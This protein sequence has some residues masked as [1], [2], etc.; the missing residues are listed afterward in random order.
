MTTAFHDT[1]LA[2]VESIRRQGIRPSRGGANF[3]DPR[4]QVYGHLRPEGPGT[5][6]PGRARIEYRVPNE[7]IIGHGTGGSTGISSRGEVP[8]EDVLHGYGPQG[9]IFEAG[10]G[11]LSLAGMLLPLIPYVN[12][13]FP[14]ASR[15]GLMGDALNAT[16]QQNYAPGG[17]MD[18]YDQWSG[19]RGST[20]AA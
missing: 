8:A 9:Q 20:V 17:Y 1:D 18:P 5:V 3:D 19:G 11:L 14:W 12:Q 16:V 6:D 13:R 4:P 10:G 7:N 15:G 2:N